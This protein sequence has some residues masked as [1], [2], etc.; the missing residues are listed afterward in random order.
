MRPGP[1]EVIKAAW[2]SEDLLYRY[3]L[4]R[5]WGMSGPPAV[6]LLLNPSTADASQDDPTIRRCIGYAR[7]WGFSAIKVV[8]LFAFRATDPS[9]LRAPGVEPIG[10]ANDMAILHAAQHAGIVV[11]GWGT[12]GELHGRGAHVRRFLLAARELH[13]LKLTAGGHP[14]HPLYLKGDLHPTLW[15][16]E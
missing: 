5:R 1:E 9:G 13:V 4:V 15:R 12:H 8:N 2:L 11:C 16:A 10:P 3:S 6:F 7:A 14:G